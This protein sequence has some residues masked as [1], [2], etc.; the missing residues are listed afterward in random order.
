[1]SNFGLV[2]TE[3][4]GFSHSM[5]SQTGAARQLVVKFWLRLD[6]GKYPW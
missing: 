4:E 2:F 1:M 3:K 5:S 6:A